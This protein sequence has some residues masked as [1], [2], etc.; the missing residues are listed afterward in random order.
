MGLSFSYPIDDYDYLDE[1][2]ESL[3]MR[4]FSFTDKVKSTLRSLSFNGRDSEPAIFKAFGSAKLIIEGSLSFNG[5]ETMISIKSPTSKKKSSKKS[6]CAS[7]SRFSPSYESPKLTAPESPQHE[8]ALKLQ[9][10]YKSFR[11]RRQLADC[12]VLVEQHWWKLLDFALL[13]RSSVSFFDIEKPETAVSKWSRARTKAAKVG[14]GLSKDEKAQKL[15]LQHWLEAI[16]PRH[17]Y[18]HNLHY[19][20]ECWLHCESKQPFFYWLDVGDG[21]EVNLEEHC[22]RLTLQQQC[23]KYLG[24]KEREAYEVIVEDGIFMYKESR[25]LL[26]TSEGPEDVKWIFV[27]STSKALYVGQKKKGTFQHSSFLAGG[28]TSAAGRLIVENG[29]LKAVWPHSGHYRPTEEN[30]R[31]FT[32]F[33]KENNVDL[34]DVKLSPTEED[35]ELGQIIRTSSS[36]PNFAKSNYFNKPEAQKK[37]SYAYDAA[38]ISI[39][40]ENASSCKAP[41]PVSR[42]RKTKRS[43]HLELPPKNIV[44]FDTQENKE[45]DKDEEEEGEEEIDEKRFIFC[46]ENLFEEGEEETDEEA[47]LQELILRRISSK[48]GVKSY[49]LGKQLSFRWTTGAGPR[50]GWVRGYPPGLQFRA[51]EQVNLSPRNLEQVNLSPRN[52]GPSRFASP[53][54]CYSP[55]PRVKETLK[56]KEEAQA[57]QMRR[58]SDR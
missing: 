6:P 35:E 58:E 7:K 46:K 28:A 48:K 54:T 56:V 2:F 20:Y 50:I 55:S 40:E 36:E 53:R 26:D 30:F 32:S 21:K 9:K 39:P 57:T 23:I 44:F 29:V 3:L 33:L 4:S 37:H 16:D 52:L 15:A 17:R 25:K 34:T 24:P 47:V 12:A 45:N 10:V 8:A 13:R 22:P 38:K 43:L 27:L 1:S 18:G 31:E 11:T 41:G 51:L 42:E 49:Q 14:K 19:Y 5:K